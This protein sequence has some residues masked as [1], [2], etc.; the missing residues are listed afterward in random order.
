LESH[1]DD[2]LFGLFQKCTRANIWTNCIEGYSAL[3]PDFLH[4]LP[5][6]YKSAQEPGWYLIFFWD[7]PALTSWKA[8]VGNAV[9]QHL[10]AP[11]RKL[12]LDELD[13]AH[14]SGAP[15]QAT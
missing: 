8:Y 9:A 3:D 12:N 14:G 6:D 15:G 7:G 4:S 1:S 10:G 13:R 2:K 11:Q 5:E